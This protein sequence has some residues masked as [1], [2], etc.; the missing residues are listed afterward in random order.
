MKSNSAV[1]TQTGAPSPATTRPVSSASS[2]RAACSTVSPGS[3]PP[4][5][6]NHQRPG[7]AVGRGPSRAAAGPGRGPSTT[8]A[9]TPGRPR[10]ARGASGGHAR[11]GYVGGS[12]VGVSS[13]TRT[14]R[15]SRSP[16]RKAGS[17]SGSRPGKN[18]SRRTG[19]PLER[20]PPVP[21]V[22]LELLRGP[23][24]PAPA[25]ARHGVQPGQHDVLVLEDPAPTA[26]VGGGAASTS[27]ARTPRGGQHEAGLLGQLSRRRSAP[28]TRRAPCRRRAA[29]TRCRAPASAGSTVGTAARRRRR[30]R[31]DDPYR[32]PLDVV[33]QARPGLGQ[34]AAVGRSGPARGASAVAGTPAAQRPTIGSAPTRPS[35]TA[36]CSAPPRRPTFSSAGW[37]NVDGLDSQDQCHDR[38][39]DHERAADD[40]VLRDG[41]A[42]GVA[43]VARASRTTRRGGRP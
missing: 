30:R 31:S 14:A 26:Q 19:D 43:Q 20:P 24:R 25:P 28:P 33:H 35:A 5:G 37:S 27:A 42:A 1:R 17:S 4:P 11:P 21:G 40:L 2:R 9:P 10:R 12:V 41:A 38:P 36:G 16:A 39:D 18:R 32:R 29:P 34:P 23:V 6:V 3:A 15:R 13:T 22:V 7:R 8:H